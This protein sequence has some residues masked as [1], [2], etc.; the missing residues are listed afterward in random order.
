MPPGKAAAAGHIHASGSGDSLHLS[1]LGEGG[2]QGGILKP[3]LCQAG[4]GEA[5]GTGGRGSWGMP[6]ATSPA[7]PLNRLRGNGIKRSRSTGTTSPSGL[8]SAGEL[9]GDYLQPSRHR[10][11]WAGSISPSSSPVSL[12][13]VS[14]M[15]RAVCGA[16]H[17]PH[18]E[19]PKQAAPSQDST[20]RH[21]ENDAGSSCCSSE[22]AITHLH[23]ES[24]YHDVFIFPDTSRTVPWLRFANTN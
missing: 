6:S 10:W 2:E 9:N 4:T 8:S 1:Q 22:G 15:T 16:P 7:S 20:S 11:G 17:A 19:S 23:E 3:E 14:S 12:H 5:R 13:R 24:T 18:L 21:W